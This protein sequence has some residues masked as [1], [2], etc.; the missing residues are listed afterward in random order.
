[1]SIC[2]NYPPFSVLISVYKNDNPSYLN[3]ALNSIEDQTVKPIEIVLVEDGPISD[4]L[5]KVISLHK[6]KFQGTF[7]DI[8]CKSNHG[9]GMAL[10]IGLN[11]VSTDWVARMDSDDY[12]LPDRF[13]KQMDV[14]LSDPDLALIGGQIKEFA[15]DITN[16]VGS[17][18]VPIN[19]EAIRQFAKWRSPFN[20]PTVLF[21]KEKV[22]SVGSYCAFGNLEDYYLWVR[23]IS[24]G[25]KVKNMK[26]YLTYMRV[27]DGMYSRRGNLNN[28]SFFY[29]LRN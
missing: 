18:I 5:K 20:H 4:K 11:Y 9:L 23:L 6:A 1:M 3:I 21:N 25:Q 28:I 24:N 2:K 7:K 22:L 12:S 14:V 8:V 19:E 13:Q 10:R 15:G 17:R 16:I 27:D 26:S 29:K